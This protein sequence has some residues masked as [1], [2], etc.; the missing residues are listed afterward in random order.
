MRFDGSRLSHAVIDA[1]QVT[2]RRSG[3]NEMPLFLGS[4][5][6]VPITLAKWFGEVAEREG[7]RRR[8]QQ[9]GRVRASEAVAAG[10]FGLAIERA[11]EFIP[12]IPPYGHMRILVLR[13]Q[14]VNHPS[15]PHSPLTPPSDHPPLVI[16]WPESEV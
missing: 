4:F 11:S 9:R 14:L 8:R 1:V 7:G 2:A 10:M 16:F 3:G 5:A 13:H 12:Q 15:T 6:S